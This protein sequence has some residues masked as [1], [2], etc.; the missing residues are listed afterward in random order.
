MPQ[1]EFADWLPQVFWLI[2]TFGTLY[3]VMS[4]I[5]LPRVTEVLQA[6]EQRI[7]NDL[8]AAA[9]L[10][11]EAQE[12]LQSYEAALADAR[13]KALALAV[14]TRAKVQAEADTKRAEAEARLN[15]RAME[16]EAQIKAARDDAMSNV[17]EIAG[18]AA[19]DVVAQLL[20]SSPDDATVDAVLDA[21][22]SRS[23]VN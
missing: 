1:L 10:N 12:A 19:R 18:T 8:D 2:V 3:L 5:A 7:A 9:R 13:S 11:Q 21:E 22:L 15:Q 4:R 6:R 23:G 17:R 16:A 20:G 14:E